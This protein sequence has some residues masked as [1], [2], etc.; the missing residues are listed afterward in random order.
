MIALSVSLST[1][2]KDG[3]PETS[4][5]PQVLKAKVVSKRSPRRVRKDGTSADSSLKGNK[6]FSKAANVKSKSEVPEFVT[7]RQL[8]P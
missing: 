6:A 7:E 4:P 3:K 5:E 2:L 8:Y 1:Y